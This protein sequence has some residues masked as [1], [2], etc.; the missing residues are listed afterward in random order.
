VT[1]NASTLDPSN[2]ANGT[3]SWGELN[4]PISLPLLGE[5]TTRLFGAYRY[6]IWNGSLGEQ[7]IYSA[8]GIS[9]EQTKDLPNLGAIRNNYYARIGYGT[10]QGNLFP[11]PP[12]L[13]FPAAAFLPH[14]TAR[15]RSGRAN[16]STPPWPAPPP[17][18]RSRLCPA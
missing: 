9:L 12:S 18:L 6:R 16:P 1:L 8:I 3:G 4:R 14:S 10:F 5:V 13:V 7:D 17:I 15:C 11:A 2:F